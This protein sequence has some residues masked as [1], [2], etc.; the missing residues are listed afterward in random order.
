[1]E[2]VVFTG[3]YPAIT[4]AVAT[5]GGTSGM[6]SIWHEV[7]KDHLAKLSDAERKLCVPVPCYVN[8]DQ[9]SLKKTFAPIQPK[10]ETGAF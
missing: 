9:N 10:Y 7:L 5:T 4:G 2:R 6:S 1:L 3:E 8:I